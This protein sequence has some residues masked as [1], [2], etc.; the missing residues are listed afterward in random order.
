MMKSSPRKLPIRFWLVFVVYQCLWHIAIPFALIRLWLRSQ[1]EAGYFTHI[2]ERFGFYQPSK[3]IKPIWIHAVSVGET[4]AVAPL[5]EA[6]LKEGHQIVLTHMT[7][8]GRSTGAEI[9]RLAISSKQLEQCFV[10]YDFCWP[11]SRF[12]KHYQPRMGL[13][14]ETEVWP[15]ILIFARNQNLLMYLINGRLSEKSA[16]NFQKFGSLSEVL[17]QAFTQILAQSIEDMA[18]YQSFG[19]SNICVTGNLKFDVQLDPEGVALGLQ[20]KKE[21]WHKRFVVCAASTREHEEEII[22]QA[23]QEL[24]MSNDKLLILVPR[25]LKRLEEIESLLEQKA[26]RWIR[27]SKLQDSFPAD[28]Q[29][30]LGDSMGEMALYLSGAEV[31]VMGGT[32]AG[33]GGQNLIEPTSLGIPVLLGP[34][35][36][37]FA[38]VSQDAL[39]Q[40]AAIELSDSTD[41]TLLA[42]RIAEELRKFSEQPSYLELHRAKAMQ[43]ASNYQGATKATLEHLFHS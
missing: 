20:W 38:K 12:L 9:F 22:L 4:R 5:I 2:A 1:K 10:P 35:T 30:L 41:P 31:I 7:P 14:M 18:R 3:L 34:S 6:L 29:V 23:W 13:L 32:L 40:G 21:W 37:N 19:V 15:S 16:K 25:H 42:K 17:F 11:V 39:L 27:R 8:S 36:Y 26:I 24:R 43:F 33:T 28:I